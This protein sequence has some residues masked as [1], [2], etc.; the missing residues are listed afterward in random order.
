[1]NKKTAIIILLFLILVGIG[2]VSY[3]YFFNNQEQ[4]TNNEVSIPE[5]PSSNFFPDSENRDPQ[6]PNQNNNNR[7]D[8]FQNIP[9]LR[10]ISNNPVSGFI[11]FDEVSTTTNELV[12]NTEE[13]GATTTEEIVETKTIYRFVNRSNGNIFETDSKKM[14]VDRISNRTIPKIQESIFSKDGENIIHRFLESSDNI[15]SIFVEILE[16]DNQNISATSTAT[17]T[18]SNEN[19][20]ENFLDLEVTNLASG[21]KDIGMHSNGLVFYT[22]ANQSNLSG[23]LFD[24][25]NVFQQSRFINSD[26]TQ[27]DIEW[28]KDN[29]ILIGTKPSDYSNGLL[30]EYN[31]DSQERK[32]ILDGGIG[33][34]F[35]AK[36]NTNNIIYSNYLG[37]NIESYYFNTETRELVDLDMSTIVSDKCAWSNLSDDVIYCAIPNNISG[38]GYPNL[39]HQGQVSFNDSLYMIDVKSGIKIKLEGLEGDFDIKNPQVSD[40]DE[41]ITFINKKDLT[42]WSLDIK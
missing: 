11:I 16:E 14:S 32:K 2:T 22:T 18:N 13:G 30:F 33:F 10:Q 27:V 21:I 17:S 9:S 4:E 23:Y 28:F 26:L 39:W 36:E 31:I 7:D 5:Q 34:N 37:G 3:F 19:S 42:L 12:N 1:M 25:D 15:K 8:G 40:N 41:Y 29:S 20:D 38:L 6:E 35:I 24:V